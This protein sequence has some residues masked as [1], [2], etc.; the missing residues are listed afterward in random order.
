MVVPAR[1]DTLCT[2][3]DPWSLFHDFHN[4]A[5]EQSISQHWTQRLQYPQ[6]S[7]QTVTPC[8]QGMNCRK[9]FTYGLSN[10]TPEPQ[11]HETFRHKQMR[12]VH[13][14]NKQH[15]CVTRENDKSV[16][17]ISYSMKGMWYDSNVCFL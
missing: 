12:K 17:S 1:C 6:C 16:Y 14:K 13:C 15:I 2:V 4:S 9:N 11:F 10:S 8:C 3:T 7:F 5:P